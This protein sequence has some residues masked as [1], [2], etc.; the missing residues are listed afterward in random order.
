MWAN[1]IEKKKKK[2]LG[3]RDDTGER[4]SDMLWL[5][6]EFWCLN[7]KTLLEELR[8]RKKGRKRRGKRVHICCVKEREEIK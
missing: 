2:D 8:K 6:M 7:K 1:G 4:K 5:C 3:L